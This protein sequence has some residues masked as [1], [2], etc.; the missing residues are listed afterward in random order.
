[1]GGLKSAPI[2]GDALISQPII[3]Q[4][5][6][7]L[8]QSHAHFMAEMVHEK[9]YKE[10]VCWWADCVKPDGILEEMEFARHILYHPFHYKAK[11]QILLYII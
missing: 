11:V 7:T 4:L 9:K 6:Y 10:F 1:M 8:S 2:I 3:G 5:L